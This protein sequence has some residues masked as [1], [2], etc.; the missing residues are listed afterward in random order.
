MEQHDLETHR[1][2]VNEVTRQANERR[3]CAACG[4]LIVGTDHGIAALTCAHCQKLFCP[5]H[6]FEHFGEVKVTPTQNQRIAHLG[7][8]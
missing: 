2:I 5:K 3:K 4:V 8:N 6:G 7:V 1:A